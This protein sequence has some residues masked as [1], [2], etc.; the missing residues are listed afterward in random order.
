[1]HTS[2]SALDTFKTCPL[3]YKY[4]EIEKRKTPKRVEQVFGT[5]VHSA[6]KYMFLRD[7]LYPALDEVIN[8]YT[9]KWK[10]AAEKIEW[11]NLERKEAQEKMYFEEGIKLLENFYKKNSPWNFNAVELESRFQ[12]NLEDTDTGTTH[13]LAGFID[14]IDKD[15]TSDVYE[16]IDYKTGKKMPSQEMLEDDLQLGLYSIAL[17]DRWPALPANRIQTSLY[18]LKHNEKISA[19]HSDEKLERAKGRILTIIKEIEKRMESGLFEP[20]PGPLCNW[21]GFR[22]ICPMWSHE[23]K[24]KEERQAPDEAEVAQAIAEFFEIKQTE[25]TNKKRLGQL[26]NI[27]LTYMEN[28]AVARVFGSPGYITKSV[29]ERFTWEMSQVKPTLERLGK[30]SGILEPNPKKLEELLP[31]LPD[32]DREEILSAREKKSVVTLKQTKKK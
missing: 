31:T 8:F 3:K 9:Q 18:F 10:E 16:I 2:Y 26:R 29:G 24:N 5:V 30:W 32:K 1:M 20:T 11:K 4:Q 25:E 17:K 6:L 14:R 19:V 12:I 28:T 15:P 22:P 23:Y 27:I 7:P 13:T 21:C